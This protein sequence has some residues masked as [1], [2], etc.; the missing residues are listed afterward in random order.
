MPLGPISPSPGRAL[1]SEESWA[2]VVA[3]KA[4]TLGE[5]DDDILEALG[6]AV[7]D[8]EAIRALAEGA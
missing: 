3:M 8:N 6:T 5:L 2:R 1:T 7:E 4:T